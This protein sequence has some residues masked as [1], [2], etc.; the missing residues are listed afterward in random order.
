MKAFDY[1]KAATDELTEH[2]IECIN[3]K[4]KSETLNEYNEFLQL[5]QLARTEITN[6][7]A[8]SN[9]ESLQIDAYQN[10]LI[11]KIYTLCSNK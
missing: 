6:L 3:R 5:M 8:I 10:E 4:S 11:L 9:S 1:F 2:F 7:Y